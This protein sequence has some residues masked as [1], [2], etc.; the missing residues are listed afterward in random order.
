MYRSLI[1]LLLA[2][3]AAPLLKAQ[4]PVMNPLTGPTVLCSSVTAN[5]GASASN[6][7]AYYFWQS[8]PST[9]VV[10][11]SQFAQNP[12][13][14]F[15]ATAGSYTLSCYATNGSGA[16]APATMV[17]TVFETPM[18]TFSGATSFC[19]GSPTNLSASPTIITP[20]SPTISYSW[21]PSTGLSS[22]TSGTV[23]A[24]PPSSTTYN[25][26]ITM[27]SCTNT[28]QVS[29][30]VL[31]LPLV[32]MA[33]SPNPIC[34]GKSST[35]TPGGNA[36]WYYL[37]PATPGFIV[38][39]QSTTTYTITGVGA[40]GCQNSAQLTLSVMQPPTVMLSANPSMICP[41]ET[42]T[43]TAFGS[44]INYTLSSNSYT[45]SPNFNTVYTALGEDA[46]GCVGTGT[47]LV[48]ILPQ[49]LVS[50]TANPVAL[51]T[52]GVATI[53]PNGSAISYTITPAIQ[54][55]TVNPTSN[56][57]Y[58]VAGMGINGCINSSI[59]VLSVLPLPTITAS[60]SPA[61]ICKG[62]TTTLT[63][64]GSVTSFSFS[65]VTP[66]Y[67]L[68][69]AA[70]ATYV[71]TGTGP[72]GC[73]NKASAAVKV[74][75]C[76][77]IRDLENIDGEKLA[78]YPNPSQDGFM[79]VSVVDTDARIFTET[80]T[81]LRRLKLSSGEPLKVT[82]LPAGIYFLVTRETSMKIV[83]R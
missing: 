33:S 13:I 22:T 51:C 64:G 16:S 35:L 7:A 39:P 66:P 46:N 18:V 83:V 19:Q 17:V 48:S 50:L 42:A 25:V 57:T 32:T 8:T 70:S 14:S 60:A 78:V 52:G 55:N 47:T 45:V 11:N 40:N 68:T 63:V 12:T 1:L 77:S 5:Y 10:F 36:S 49:P 67:I 15:P 30:T 74:N 38:T 28:V 29:L 71:A 34:A 9:G 75:P 80:G 4:V 27:N 44:A 21:T 79:I 23:I 31:P 2:A 58:S 54:N 59:L 61:T 53:T 37:T 62:E 82:G 81:E 69:P 56:T 24:N 76:T 65:N 41:G 72:N 6:S 20:G 43:L 26:L 3:I 73:T